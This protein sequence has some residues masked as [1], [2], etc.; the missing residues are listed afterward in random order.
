MYLLDF[1]VV[2]MIS[3]SLCVTSPSTNYWR[4]YAC[5]LGSRGDIS[6]GGERDRLNGKPLHEVET[7]GAGLAG[8]AVFWYISM[9]ISVASRSSR[10]SSQA[11]VC[12]SSR[13]RACIS[14]ML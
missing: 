13:I 4:W 7:C 10:T 8:G 11:G 12:N 6:L 14:E 1:F 9:R 5:L 2:T 3:L